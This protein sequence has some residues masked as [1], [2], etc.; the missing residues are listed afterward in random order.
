M[1]KIAMM[2]A[3]FL[4][5]ALAPTFASAQTCYDQMKDLP[6]WESGSKCNIHFRNQT[7]ENSG[8]GNE[9]YNQITAVKTVRVAALDYKRL[10]I[11]NAKKIL[12]PQSATLNLEKK[13]GFG[14][15]HIKVLENDF[16]LKEEVYMPCSDVLATLRGNGTCSVFIHG[17][18]AFPEKLAV[19]YN[20]DGGNVRGIALR[21]LLE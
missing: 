10:A 4:A 15:I 8:N 3:L 17:T 9:H 20:C 6:C 14:S 5:A 18:T 19:A 16:A 12:A 2:T 7:G 11:G 1:K 13:K 21:L